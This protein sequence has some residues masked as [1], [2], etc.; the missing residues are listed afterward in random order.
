M[1]VLREIEDVKPKSKIKKHVKIP[2]S[3]LRFNSKNMGIVL[4]L[5]IK[6]LY[7]STLAKILTLLVHYLV[8]L[9]NATI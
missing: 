2:I 1:D 5:L 3:N 8:P 4:L 9:L 7:F 6:S